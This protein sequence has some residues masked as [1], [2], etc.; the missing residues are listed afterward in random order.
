VALSFLFANTESGC[1]D[2][3]G[4]L[5]VRWKLLPSDS[6]SDGGSN[7]SVT[8]TTMATNNRTQF[9]LYDQMPL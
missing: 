8:R 2:R 6:A 4:A 3:R 1:I 5:L 9:M 7:A